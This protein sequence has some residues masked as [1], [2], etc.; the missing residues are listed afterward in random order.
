MWNLGRIGS[1]LVKGYV[2]FMARH[3]VAQFIRLS[4]AVLLVL[5]SQAY[6]VAQGKPAAVGTMVICQ[7]NHM[8]TVAIDADGQ[9][10]ETVHICPDH[11]LFVADGAPLAGVAKVT[12]LVP[13]TF[14]RLPAFKSPQKSL[15]AYWGRGPPVFL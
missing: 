2:L 14:T 5:T 10:V 4:L 8:V 15:P 6:A 7:G 1:D 9:P 13:V 12:D 3:W 11:A